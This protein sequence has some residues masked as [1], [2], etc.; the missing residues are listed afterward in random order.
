MLLRAAFRILLMLALVVNGSGIARADVAPDVAP[1]ATQTALAAQDAA[2]PC[3]GTGSLDA[4]GGE[5][6]PLPHA[7]TAPDDCSGA[8]C[9]CACLHGAPLPVLAGLPAAPLP[10]RGQAFPAPDV[11]YPAPALGHL[12]RPPIPTA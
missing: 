10:A 1:D 12:I 4:H 8:A 6:A 7:P 3:H 11:A 2:P 9:R 5:Q